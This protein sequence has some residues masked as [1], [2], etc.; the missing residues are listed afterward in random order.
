MAIAETIYEALR[1]NQGDRT[2]ITYKATG[3]GPMSES[4]T[5]TVR[6]L[7]VEV[8]FN[9]DGGNLGGTASEAITATINDE[10]GSV[11]DDL[12]FSQDMETASSTSHRPDSEKWTGAGDSIDLAYANTASETWGVVLKIAQLYGEHK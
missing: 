3:S 11:Y 7:I 4:I 8:R 9:I 5:P 2:I 12:F 1:E 6:S 10:H